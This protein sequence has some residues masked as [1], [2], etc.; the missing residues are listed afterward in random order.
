MGLLP[1]F[2]ASHLT[3]LMPNP[4]EPAFDQAKEQVLLHL[5]VPE[6]LQFKPTCQCNCGAFLLLFGLACTM[7]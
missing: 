7:T 1:D 5:G 2:Y 4:F 6:A 3:S